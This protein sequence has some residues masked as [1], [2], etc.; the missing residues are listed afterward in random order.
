MTLLKWK[1]DNNDTTIVPIADTD[2]SEP[3]RCDPNFLELWKL[4]EWGDGDF[5]AYV[6]ANET[7]YFAFVKFCIP[8]VTG[9]NKWRND[10][11]I[12][13]WNRD[14][15]TLK[16][17]GMLTDA[18]EGFAALIV[19]NG[20][21]R[22]NKEANWRHEKG[23]A[24]DASTKLKSPNEEFGVYK[25]SDGGNLENTEGKKGRH[26][27]S[28]SG[29]MRYQE[30]KE[31]IKT[32]ETEYD[33]NNALVEGNDTKSLMVRFRESDEKWKRINMRDGAGNAEDNNSAYGEQSNE[34]KADKRQKRD[35]YLN[36][37]FKLNW[38][39]V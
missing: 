35:E 22:W 19:E 12:A 33:F 28:H 26:D 38:A 39:E 32:N 4:A 27:W 8:I 34:D 37:T 20:Y 2:A 30:I 1:T 17:C 21:E 15:H 10:L 18:E 23:I 13:I 14:R 16:S 31:K 29:L 6:R 36:Q 9:V 25:W 5:H 7:R 3:C 11:K 24:Y